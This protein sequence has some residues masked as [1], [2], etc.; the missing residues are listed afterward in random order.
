LSIRRFQARLGDADE[1]RLLAML[2][3]A[4]S[5]VS[6]H[7]SLARRDGVGLR[8]IEHLVAGFLDAAEEDLVK[9]SRAAKR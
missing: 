1:D 2:K 3:D 8:R 6:W 7:L 4:V 9:L 5:A